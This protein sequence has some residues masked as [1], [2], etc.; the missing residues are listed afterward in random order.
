ME[1]INDLGRQIAEVFTMNK[2]ISL[3]LVA[4]GFALGKLF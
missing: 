4:I 3:I 2:K 1:T